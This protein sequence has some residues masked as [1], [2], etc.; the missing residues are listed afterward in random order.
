MNKLIKEIS[1]LS[2]GIKIMFL[3]QNRIYKEKNYILKSFL[4]ILVL[5]NFV[6]A[7]EITAELETF[8]KSIA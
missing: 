6:A 7:Q 4:F 5:A 8:K 1:N 3:R 2:D